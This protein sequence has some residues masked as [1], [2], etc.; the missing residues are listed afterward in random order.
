MLLARGSSVCLN[1]SKLLPLCVYAGFSFFMSNPTSKSTAS[2]KETAMDQH[3]RLKAQHPDCVLM[4]RVGDFYETFYEDAQLIAPALGLTLTKRKD[5]IPLAGIPHHQLETYLRRMLD[6]GFRVAVA[7]QIQDPKEAKGVV[8]RAV[9]R[10]VTPGTLIDESLMDPERS[11]TLAA[12]AFDPSNPALVGLAVI[13]PAT[14]AFEV[15]E[16]SADHARDELAR[17]RPSEIIYATADIDQRTPE[18]IEHLVA[19]LDAALTPKPVWMFRDQQAERCLCEQ[20]AVGTLEAFGLGDPGAARSAAGAVV[21]YLRETQP[22]ST[23]GKHLRPPTRKDAAGVLDATS[24]RALEIER[25]LRG[26]DL[27][28]SLLGIFLRPGRA[29]GIMGQPSLCRTPMGKRLLRDWLCRPLTT[30]QEVLDRQV[31][32]AVLVEDERLA[33]EVASALDAVRDVARIGGRLALSRAT[34]RDV[35]S[36]A[37]SVRAAE[38]LAELLEGVAAFAAV[39]TK[40]IAACGDLAP[41]A[42]EIARSCIEEPPAH[43]R[44]GGLFRDGIDAQ[45]DAARGL[46]RDAGEWLAQYQTKLIEQHSLPTLKVGFNKVFGYYLELTAAQAREHAEALDRSGLTR[47]QTLKN[48]ERYTTPELREFEHKVSTAEASAIE[49]ESALFVELC[50]HAAAHTEPMAVLSQAVAELDATGAFAAKARTSGWVRPTIVDEPVL[51]IE[52]GRHPVLDETLGHRFVPNPICLGAVE[53]HPNQSD[54]SHHARAHLALITGPNMA[55]K[56][57][58]IRQT[59]LLAVLAQVGS[60]LPAARATVGICD[61]ICTRVGA[62]DALHQGRSTFMVEM[63]ETAS[64]LHQAT[65]RSLVVLDEI[66]RGTSTLDGLSLAWAITEHLARPGGPRTLFATH[67][68][69]LTD[70]ADTLDG[71]LKNLHVAVREFTPEPTEQVPEPASELVFIHRILPGRADQS[72]GVH[73]AE[74]AGVPPEVV[75]RAREVLGSLAVEH[76]NAPSI[77]SMVPPPASSPVASGQLPLFTEYL[78]HPAISRLREVKLDA[79]TPLEAFD[80]LRELRASIES[81]S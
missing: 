49:R 2:K 36:L 30:R 41:M 81:G 27:D 34:P 53:T 62:D 65:E 9:T 7:D 59:A 38:N 67:Y 39:R 45:L 68:H 6:L 33:D 42:D 11:S 40:L 50:A 70:L 3:A 57:T 51:D 32:V 77:R 61:R 74:L 22:T 60:F 58:F 63:T 10:V 79:L 14:G 4:F 19:G 75:R 52:D 28:G 66:G 1:R 37:Q 47:Q 26:N 13:D 73:V 78:P 43:L 46:Q 15:F 21:Q 54:P 17:I 12:L 71:S 69:E 5:G 76:Q 64:I 16:G 18:V 48:A 24:M 8:D 56:S 35:V 29:A 23:P 31:R 25:T 80:L 55:G 20:F 44:A 72:Y